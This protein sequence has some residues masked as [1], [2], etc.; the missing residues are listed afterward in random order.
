MD[1]STPGFPVHHQLLELTQTH[2]HRVGDAIS[3]L[4]MMMLHGAL[5]YIIQCPEMAG[6]LT[7]V[8]KSFYYIVWRLCL[9]LKIIYENMIYKVQITRMNSTRTAINMK[10]RFRDFPGSPVAKTPR[11]QCRGLRF[12]SWSGYKSPHATAKSLYAPIKDP[13][14]HT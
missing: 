9:H 14:C 6:I 10:M 5:S 4:V 1:C 7:S 2:V 11:S 12:H 3:K 8:L 13:A